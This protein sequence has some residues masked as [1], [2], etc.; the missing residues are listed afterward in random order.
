MSA[1]S[2]ACAHGHYSQPRLLRLGDR[3]ARGLQADDHVAAR[4]R[5]IHGVGMALRSKTD[6]G[7]FLV[8][9]VVQ[10]RVFIVINLHIS[11]RFSLLKC[12]SKCISKS[13]DLFS[14]LAKLF[15]KLPP[16]TGLID[17]PQ[18]AGSPQ[19]S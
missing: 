1:S 2:A 3:R 14:N 15:P 18:A 17:L 5:Q 16:T 6:H 11:S 8:L 13:R 4:I 7:N 19:L 10:I 9:D 12:V